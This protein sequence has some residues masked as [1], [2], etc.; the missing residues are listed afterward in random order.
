MFYADYSGGS[1]QNPTQTIVGG[2]GE[3]SI[4]QVEGQC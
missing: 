3:L 2:S 1:G 4:E